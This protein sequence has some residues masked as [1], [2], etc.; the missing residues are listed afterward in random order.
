MRVGTQ[1]RNSFWASEAIEK[2][3]SRLTKT[4]TRP[5]STRKRENLVISAGYEQHE[6]HLF[7]RLWNDNCSFLL[8]FFGRGG[9]MI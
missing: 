9:T 6:K 7:H 5:K 3:S 8:P 1:V 4:F 2:V